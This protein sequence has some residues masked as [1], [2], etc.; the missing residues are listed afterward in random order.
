M[1]ERLMKRTCQLGRGS[2]LNVERSSPVPDSFLLLPLPVC[3]KKYRPSTRYLRISAVPG[4]FDLITPGPL[5]T[6][7]CVAVP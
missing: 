5:N 2:N 4:D 1:S 3:A 7:G 6:S